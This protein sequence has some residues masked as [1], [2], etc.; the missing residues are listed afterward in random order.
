MTDNKTD[1]NTDN[2][3]GLNHFDQA[4]EIESQKADTLI[5]TESFYADDLFAETES[6]EQSAA[7]QAD[8]FDATL[9]TDPFSE[10]GYEKKEP[11]IPQKAETVSEADMPAPEPAAEQ[12]QRSPDS[13]TEQPVTAAP[14]TDN[15][16]SKPPAEQRSGT[17]SITIF[18]ILAMLV[19]AIAVWLNPGAS[20]SSDSDKSTA[21]N[22]LP[23]LAADVQIQRLEARISS[24][25]ERSSQQNDA[26]NQQV[27][28]LQQQLSALTSQLTK[29]AAKQAKK[30][31]PTRPA[32][33]KRSA[34]PAHRPSTAALSS[35][36]NT[37]WVVNLA[38]VDSKYA[39]IK[40]QS[41]YKARGI[42]TEI[43]AAVIR[44]K[45]WYR[46]RIG[47]FASKK[48]AIAQKH[49]LAKKHG[50]KDAWVQKP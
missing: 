32:A 43:H 19:A 26:L 20:T 38:S 3:F 49:Y 22:P 47:G 10:P 34:P 33:A 23:V 40:A 2:D 5:E 29:Q 9:G 24:L 39:A 4:G 6:A 25:E 16:L 35:I 18:A 21:L 50:I 41:R 12:Q 13:K 8:P 42:M 17:K 48:E 30:Q 11:S 1:S 37:G 28:R 7:E 36:Q 14:I 46:L 27:E 15:P 45:T 31:Q 44:G